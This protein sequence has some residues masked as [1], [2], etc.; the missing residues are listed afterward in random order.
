MKD[1]KDNVCNETLAVKSVLSYIYY[2]KHLH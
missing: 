1:V 2:I